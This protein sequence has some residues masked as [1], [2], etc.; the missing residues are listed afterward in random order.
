[1]ICGPP[2]RHLEHDR[3]GRDLVGHLD[4]VIGEEDLDRGL[5]GARVD[6]LVRVLVALAEAGAEGAGDEDE[7]R[8]CGSQR[9]HVQ[10][11]RMSPASR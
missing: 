3:S 5:A 9:S 2:V 10:A 4:R 8:Q 6:A 11:Y 7:R 1:V